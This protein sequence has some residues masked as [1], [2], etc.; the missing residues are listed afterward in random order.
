MQRLEARWY[1]EVCMKEGDIDHDLFKFAIL[2]FNMVQET[3][4]ND[5]KDM[6]RWWED[7]GLGSHPKLSFARDRLMECFFWTTG[8]IGDPRF[9]YY[10]KWYTKLNTMVTTIDDVYDVYGTLDELMLLREAV[11]NLARMAQC[12]YQDGDGHGVPDK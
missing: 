3:H 2:N 5:L 12:M 8:V 6:S 10:K 4:Q 7:L 1:T 11:V 9:Y